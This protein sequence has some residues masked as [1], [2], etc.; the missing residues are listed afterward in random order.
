MPAQAVVLPPEVLR[1]AAVHYDQGNGVQQDSKRA[2]QL[3]CVAA[4]EGDA[5]AARRLVD[6]N[7]DGLG[8]AADS[9]IA[10]GWLRY[11]VQHDAASVVT[12]DTRLVGGRIT[13]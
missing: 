11:A 5:V 2:Y 1:E 3:Y 8:R 10:A 4:L 7:L 13:S 12:V 6:V 9:A